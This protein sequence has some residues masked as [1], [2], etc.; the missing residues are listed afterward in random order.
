[1]ESAALFLNI[2][3]GGGLII[4]LV[5]MLSWLVYAKCALAGRL[6]IAYDILVCRKYRF[7]Y[8]EEDCDGKR[9][10]VYYDMCNLI[11]E[12]AQLCKKLS[13]KPSEQ[14][15]VLTE[16]TAKASE[17]FASLDNPSEKSTLHFKSMI[18]RLSTA[19]ETEML[20][21]KAKQEA[22][23]AQLEAEQANAFEQAFSS[24]PVS[25]D[26]ANKSSL[27]LACSKLKAID[28]SAISVKG[29]S[30][31]ASVGEMAPRQH[32]TSIQNGVSTIVASVQEIC[33]VAMNESTLSIMLSELLKLF[34]CPCPWDRK[35]LALVDDA[36]QKTNLYIERLEVGSDAADE[37]RRIA[38][39]RGLVNY[40]DLR[41]AENGAITPPSC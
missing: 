19:L 12:Y 18:V 29:S 11:E 27:D 13:Q 40:I 7:F 31:L 38:D 37:M 21:L 8:D 15:V 16:V 34:E 5:A 2:L 6:N 3:V 41:L 32:I 1:M 28:C 20:P 33:E 26:I 24:A 22:K 30:I 17:H 36:V 10:S 23:T 35:Y 25:P 9:S 39:V 4:G 14:L